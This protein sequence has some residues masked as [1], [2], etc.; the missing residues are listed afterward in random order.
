ML[1][2]YNYFSEEYDENCDNADVLVSNKDLD[3]E[4]DRVAVFIRAMRQY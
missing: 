4:Q 2:L 3:H 1:R